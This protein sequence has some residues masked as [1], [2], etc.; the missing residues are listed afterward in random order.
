M[1]DE[2]ANAFKFK[3]RV[4]IKCFELEVKIAKALTS[5]VHQMGDAAVASTQSALEH[6]GIS[7]TAV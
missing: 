2:I 3:S 7:F 1:E 5:Y 6:A 4:K